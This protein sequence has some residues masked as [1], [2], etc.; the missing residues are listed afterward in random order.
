MSENT[1]TNTD[2]PITILRSLISPRV[3][4]ELLTLTN[5]EIAALFA[6]QSVKFGL[7]DKYLAGNWRMLAQRISAATSLRSSPQKKTSDGQTDLES[8]IAET[9]SGTKKQRIPPTRSLPG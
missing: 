9:K 8:A 3:I 2:A 1:E 6:T 7:K 5:E 4:G